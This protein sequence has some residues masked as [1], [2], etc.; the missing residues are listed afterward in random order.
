MRSIGCS[1]YQDASLLISG[2]LDE[3]TLELLVV[4]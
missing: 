1:N 2:S 3:R 4:A